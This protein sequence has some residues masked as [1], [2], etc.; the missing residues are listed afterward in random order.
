MLK[1]RILACLL[2]LAMLTGL[3]AN[4]GINQ[5][6]LAAD[7]EK[8][9]LSSP[10]PMLKDKAGTFF[11]FTVDLKYQGAQ[12]KVFDL[13]TE[14]PP[15]SYATIQTVIDPKG[16][17]SIRLDP[18]AEW[19]SELNVGFIPA[20][21]GKLPEPGEYS[22]TFKA[23]SGNIAESIV[24]TAM[25]TVKYEFSVLP[26]TGRYNADITAGQD[27]LVTV[28]LQNNSSVAVKEVELNLSKPEGWGATFNPE[29]VDSIAAQGEKVVDVVI[30]PPR[31]TIAGDYEV[32]VTAST[33]ELLSDMKLRVTVKTPAV[34]GWVGILIV[35]GVVGGLA[36]IFRQ[37]G[38]R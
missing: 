23:K 26:S 32:K 6:V 28:I 7:E 8:L 38:R 27:N 36:V 2:C 1:K 29:K 30:K 21:T 25:V 16:I 9:I 5:S 11:Q 35:V 19:A 18:A 37:L 14:I 33:K 10:Y 12:P 15:G 24:L 34:W 4:L 31:N 17:A 3:A 20:L 22:L 13:S